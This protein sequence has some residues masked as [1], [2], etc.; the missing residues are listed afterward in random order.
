MNFSFELTGDRG[1]ALVTRYPT[2]CEDALM[3]STFETYTTDHYE[4]WVAFARDKQYGNDIQPILVSGFDMTRDFAMVA[5]SNE[6]SPL[7]SNSNIAVPMFATTSFRGTWRTKHSPHTNHGPQQHGPPPHE[8][9]V[10]FPLSQLGDTGSIT[11]NFNQ[12]VFIRY[13]TMRTRKRMSMFFKARPMKAGAGPHDLGPGDNRGDS[14]PEL[15]TQSNVEHT[16]GSDEDLGGNW[17]PIVDDTGSELDIVVR[18]T[19]YVWFLL[20]LFA[21]TLTFAFRMRNMTVGMS[22]QIMYSR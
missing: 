7:R 8:R 3:E 1:A 13:Y 4:S 15:T 21:S 11:N 20:C 12:C 14:F 17:A 9:T 6:G 2:Y 10:Y 19:P 16:A 5:Y 18:N 22:L